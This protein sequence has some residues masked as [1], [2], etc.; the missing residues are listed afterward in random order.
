MYSEKAKPNRN[1]K[2]LLNVNLQRPDIITNL[3]P[4]DN[5]SHSDLWS[6]PHDGD[7]RRNETDIELMEHS[8]SNLK[9]N[10]ERKNK[11]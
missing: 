10:K 2:S 11:K 7:H 4:N 8:N 9:T 1:S 6:D 3:S 5:G